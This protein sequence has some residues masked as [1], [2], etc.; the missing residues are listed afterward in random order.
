MLTKGNWRHLLQY[1]NFIKGYKSWLVLALILL[2]IVVPVFEVWILNAT[3]DI[4]NQFNNSNNRE[5]MLSY[6]KL[7][8]I[9]VAISAVVN[10][11]LAL[12]IA[13]NNSANEEKSKLIVLDNFIKHKLSEHDTFDF[14]QR[15]N[16]IRYGLNN[17]VEG[18][19][20]IISGL[21]S[22][23]IKV[24]VLLAT[25]SLL[26]N[27]MLI[28]LLIIF[29]IPISII[30]G[31]INRSSLILDWI[32]SY[33]AIKSRYYKGLLLNTSIVSEILMNKSSKFMFG[34]WNQHMSE[35]N[36]RDY[37]AGV[38]QF[39]LSLLLGILLAS[40]ITI[41]IANVVLSQEIIANPGDL[42]LIV[43][44]AVLIIMSCENLFSQIQMIG[45][46]SNQYRMFKDYIV[47]Q[48]NERSNSK[49]LTA[50][51]LEADKKDDRDLQINNL[52]YRFQNGSKLVL[53][54]ITLR[55]SSGEKIAIVGPNGAGK[56]TL[57]HC[58]MGLLEPTA[59][60]VQINGL[61]PHQ[62]SPEERAS[63]F[64]PV[65][66]STHLYKGISIMDNLKVGREIDYAM[67]D[68]MFKDYDYD[69]LYG[70]H[71]G[72]VE[73]SGGQ[74]QKLGI[75]KGLLGKGILILD[76]PTA[77]LDPMAEQEVVTMLLR[78]TRDRIVILTTHRMGITLQFDR[79]IVLNQGRIVQDGSPQQ[80]LQIEG[81]FKEMFE[82]QGQI[83]KQLSEV[84]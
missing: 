54:D 14:Q 67:I 17:C 79:V 82:S 75:L 8:F 5:D 7:L 69:Q 25:V 43:T 34:K 84:E 11:I 33:N 83:Y 70:G 55:L 2:S 74:I 41:Y 56:T 15:F 32:N 37:K 23:L 76:E 9:L 21:I 12:V 16:L 63:L 22:S 18:F 42:F 58:M 53:D 65:F 81:L 60:T 4:I 64:S 49:H 31:Y 6:L 59:G 78:Q 39:N 51:E 50:S 3:K 71:L 38:K 30:R 19:F 62:L 28:V 26:N 44:A 29:V 24:I 35:I 72:G 13:L 46:Q 47:S 48:T 20:V 1:Y 45:F 77:S 80:L 66:Q 40:L 10:W 36:Q 57:Y 61:H 52:S 27:V 73:L 68:A